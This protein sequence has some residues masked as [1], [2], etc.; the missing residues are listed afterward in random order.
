MGVLIIAIGR[1]SGRGICLLEEGHRPPNAEA[2]IC[3]IVI[4]GWIWLP[5]S[6]PAGPNPLHGDPGTFMRRGR[7]QEPGTWNR[8]GNG[9]GNCIQVPNHESLF[10]GVFRQA[11]F[12]LATPIVLFRLY[13]YR[14][15]LFQW[16]SIAH[17]RCFDCAGTSPRGGW[18]LGQHTS[19]RGLTSYLFSPSLFL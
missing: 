16:K 13:L 5:P 18:V 6:Q 12:G 10:E 17:P 14:R 11:F 8:R 15:R 9:R 3:S 4:R 1:V 19:N 7:G 2:V